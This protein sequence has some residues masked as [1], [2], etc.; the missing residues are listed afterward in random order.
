MPLEDILSDLAEMGGSGKRWRGWWAILGL[1][2]GAG[3][4]GWLAYTLGEGGFVAVA[5]GIGSGA[6]I[7]W[8]VALLLR[9]FAIFLLIFAAILAVTFGWEWLTG[10]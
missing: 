9:G 6:L 10:G 5:S 1:L 2:V 8:F 4:G 3:L 7:G